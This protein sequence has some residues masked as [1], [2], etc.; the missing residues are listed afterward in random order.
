MMSLLSSGRDGCQCRRGGK[1]GVPA[2]RLPCYGTAH[3]TQLM[4]LAAIDAQT[5]QCRIQ[6]LVSLA[7]GTITLKGAGRRVW[8]R[9]NDY[10]SNSSWF[11]SFVDE[12]YYCSN[13]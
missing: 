1:K 3:D 11:S 7:R 13:W 10:Y 9:Y 12:P 6:T 5:T 4:W 2:R 8:G